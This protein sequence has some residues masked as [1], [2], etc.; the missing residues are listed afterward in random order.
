MTHPPREAPD[1]IT[2]D[3]ATEVAAGSR[4]RTALLMLGALA[5]VFGDIGTSPLYA[6]RECFIGSHGA[7]L[8]P[9]NILGVLSLFFWGLTLEVSI[10]YLTVIFRADND[11]EGGILALLALNLTGKHSGK[12][13]QLEKAAVVLGLVGAGLLYG[14]GVITPAISVLSAV[15]GLEIIQP[16][17]TVA[18]LPLTVLILVGLF[19]LQKRG[20]GSI[21]A[22]F[23][24]IMAVWFV[25]IALVGLPWILRHPEVLAALNPY[26]ALMFF[27]RNKLQGFLVLGAVILCITGA[28]A[29]YADMGHFGK[30]PIRAT[31]FALVL[32]CLLINYFGQGAFLLAEGEKALQNPFYGM[33]PGWLLAP[34]VVLATVATVIA[35][36]ALISGAF[37]MTQQAIQLGYL[38]RMNIVHTSSQQMGQIYIPQVNVLL[39]LLSVALVLS[40]GSS[41]RL[42]SMYGIAVIGTMTITSLLF[43][44]AARN[45]LGMGR[46]M[47]G[48]AVGGFLLVDLSFLGANAA[49][50]WHGG[51][52]P[53]LLAGCIFVIMMTW[54]TGIQRL[55]EKIR[56][57]ALPLGMFV[58]EVETHDVHRAR[59]TA[60]FLTAN[61]GISPSALVHHFKHNQVLHETVVVLSLVF[62]RTPKVPLERSVEIIPLGAGFFQVVAHYGFMQT[63]NV[64][65]VLRMCAAGG[66]Q[67]DVMRSSYYLGRETVILT[68]RPGMARWRKRMFLF[69]F[70]N[71]RSVTP[72]FKLPPNR[73]IEIGAEIEF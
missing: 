34:L 23:G 12:H 48:L 22:Y 47:A 19:S 16:S 40:F 51:W 5:V 42:A 60:I 68:D 46:L 3:P 73:V 72:T 50:F 2:Q 15:E 8:T 26:H 33:A 10:K 25:S 67:V 65:E 11:G 29:L 71:A 39:M 20:T 54:S 49:K 37:S 31:W 57:G 53:V 38:P 1:E 61:T 52:L 58:R 70:T 18:V 27:V 41:T 44:Q 14:D 21:G 28:E 6:L 13:K 17:L 30:F 59:G 55:M 36:Q 43:F 64:P 56:S 9:E 45:H 35:S 4:K 69:L 66:L 7:A 32:P 62:E 24:P 63:P